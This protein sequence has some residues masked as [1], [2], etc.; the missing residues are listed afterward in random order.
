MKKILTKRLLLLV[1]VT[2]LMVLAVGVGCASAADVTWNP[3]DKGSQILLS[4]NNL[5]AELTTATGGGVRATVGMN[6]GK[7]YWEL[8]SSGTWLGFVGVAKA[9][10]NMLETWIPNETGAM[11]YYPNYGGYVINEPGYKGMLTTCAASDTIGIALDLDNKIINYY[12]NGTLISNNIDISAICNGSALYPSIN[13]GDVR[14][15][16]ANF[17]ATPFQYTV[18]SGYS[19]FNQSTQTTSPNNLAASAGNAQVTLNWTAVT[20][21]TSYNVKRATTTGGPYTQIAS[22]VTTASYTDTTVTNGTTYY[23]VVT[24]VI[25]GTE[26]GNSNE[27]SATPQTGTNPPPSGGSNALLVINMADGSEREYQLSSSQ[28]TAFITWYES[29][30]S[31]T[32]YYLF[33]KTYNLGPFTSR[34]NYVA[35]DKIIDFEVMEY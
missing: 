17:G 35:F 11:G 8:T 33:N 23:Y 28:I 7:W 20:G 22:G 9:D 34:K 31:S 13:L 3:N 19:A 18:P 14:K 32:P 12:R 26:S 10:S 27:A 25:S 21:A 2:A 15:F 6:S 30:G 16:T 5:S 1:A 4:N 29:K 24:A